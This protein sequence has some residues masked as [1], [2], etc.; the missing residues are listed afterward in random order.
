MIYERQKVTLHIYRR[1]PWNQTG[2][3]VKLSGKCPEALSHK[4]GP[5]PYNHMYLQSFN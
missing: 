5:D 3:M 2:L 1:L 4:L